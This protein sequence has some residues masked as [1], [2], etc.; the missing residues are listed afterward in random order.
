MRAKNYK[1]SH[2]YADNNEMCVYRNTELL[3]FFLVQ[4]FGNGS[5]YYNLEYG[6]L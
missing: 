2:I 5:L 3:I 1:N 6:S 4:L